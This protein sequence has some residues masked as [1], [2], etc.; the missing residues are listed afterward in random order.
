MQDSAA[1]AF[2][3]PSL[4]EAAE[5]APPKVFVRAIVAVPAMPWDQAR[6]ARLEASLNAPTALTE[7]AFVLKR[8]EPW[9]PGTPA[10]FAAVYARHADV[11]DG[12]AI[13]PQFEGRP[14]PV[15]FTSPE[16]ARAR[17]RLLAVTMA[18]SAAAVFLLVTVATTVWTLRAEAAQRLDMLERQ[19]Q[20]RVV[21]ARAAARLTAQARALDRLD[22]RRHAAPE[23]LE[24]IAWTARAV[25]PDANID[26]YHW[27]NGVLAV[28]ARGEESPFAAA[29]RPVRRSQRPVR[30]GVWLWG[31]EPA[32]TQGATP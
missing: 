11:G 27:E 17:A 13:A 16:Y 30:S 31:V 7:V 15:R 8:L 28:E 9:R 22:L 1:L 3:D 24:D 5:T 32:D 20:R 21:E 12:L 25:R 4:D 6:A 23:I 10:R 26:A 18:V 2:E 19:T 29:D 14:L